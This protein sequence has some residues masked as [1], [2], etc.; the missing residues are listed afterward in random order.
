MPRRLL[1]LTLSVASLFVTVGWTWYREAAVGTA[2]SAA[3]QEFLSSLDDAQRS[4]ATMEYGDKQRVDWHFIPKETRKGLLVSEMTEEQKKVAH[5]L[6]RSALSQAGYDKSTQI[7]LLEKVLQE[8]EGEG[9]RFPR[10]WQMYYFTIFGDP[11]GDSRWGLSVEGHH[12][13]LNF[14]AKGGRLVSTTPQVMGANPALIQNENSAGFKVGSRVLA[15]E[16]LLGFDLVNSLSD[17]QR[18]QA[19]IAE[20]ALKEVTTAG[21]PQPQQEPP[22]GIPAGKLT[23]DQRKVLRELIDEYAQAM[24]ASVAR[25]RWKEIEESGFNNVHFAWAGATEPGIGHYYRIQGET[26][27]VEFVNTQPDAAGN[28]ANHIHCLWRD[29]RGDFAIR[30]K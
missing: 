4:K 22:V 13:S 11:A 3:A 12:L 30:L 15:K 24:P 16:E 8:F 19:I 23:S 25:K 6:L 29:L 10:D 1:I 18:E 7:M 26:F 21:E 27:V 9:R 2:M 5:V 20:K 17:G 14:V 28:P